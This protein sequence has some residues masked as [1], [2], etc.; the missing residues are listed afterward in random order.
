VWTR[1]GAHERD[2]ASYYVHIN[3]LFQAGSETCA[4]LNEIVA[5]GTG[6]RT[7]GGVGHNIFQVL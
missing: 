7:K 2:A 3:P 4:R 5:V 6:Y 1:N